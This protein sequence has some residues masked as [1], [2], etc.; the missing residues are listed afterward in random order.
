MNEETLAV[1][2]KQID[3]DIVEECAEF[4]TVETAAGASAASGHEAAPAGAAPGENVAASGREKATG[5]HRSGRKSE[6]P[7]KSVVSI[8]ATI[9]LFVAGAAAAIVLTVWN[10]NKK[11]PQETVVATGE[12]YASQYPQEDPTDDAAR[13]LPPTDAPDA[14]PDP[15][16]SPE[17]NLLYIVND[18]KE[19]YPHC[20]LSWSQV[21]VALAED[22]APSPM[23]A[24][25]VS[26][27]IQIMSLN[28]DDHTITYNGDFALGIEERQGLSELGIYRYIIYDA[29]LEEVFIQRH[30]VNA[31]VSAY[32]AKAELVR[33]LEEFFG[34]TEEPLEPY[35]VCV[36]VSYK[37]RSIFYTEDNESFDYYAYDYVF[38]VKKGSDV[39]PSPTICGTAT[40]GLTPTETPI[41][42]NAP[43]V[44][45][46]SSL[47]FAIVQDGKTISP[48]KAGMVQAVTYNGTEFVIGDL[49]ASLDYTKI[50]AAAPTVYYY[51]DFTEVWTKGEPGDY[52]V[53]SLAKVNKIDGTKAVSISGHC[54]RLSELKRFLPSD[55]T[56][57]QY[58]IDM[59]IAVVIT[60]RGD[61]VNEAGGYETRQVAYV[62]RI[63]SKDP[64]QATAR[65]DPTEEPSATIRI[66][67]VVIE[68][69]SKL[70]IGETVKLNCRVYPDNY[71]TGSISWKIVEGGEYAQL[72]RAA[73]TVKGVK[74]GTVRLRA[75]VEG[76]EIG[77]EQIISVE[78]KGLIYTPDTELDPKY[79]PEK[80]PQGI[81][82]DVYDQRR[83]Y[84]VYNMRTPEEVPLQRY[85][86][87][88]MDMTYYVNLD[89]A[90]GGLDKGG[91]KV[92]FYN[93]DFEYVGYSITN[94]S[95]LAMFTVK[96]S[97]NRRL[98]F[99]VYLRDREPEVSAFSKDLRQIMSGDYYSYGR[100]GETGLACYYKYVFVTDDR[101]GIYTVSFVNRQTG[102][103][104][105]VKANMLDWFFVL[106]DCT[107]YNINP[108]YKDPET[109]NLVDVPCLYS[110]PGL[111]G[112]IDAICY[113]E[114]GSVDNDAT[115][116]AD[117]PHLDY[118]VEGMHITIYLDGEPRDPWA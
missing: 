56:V 57:D 21:M 1:Y 110:W 29:N 84:L 22:E 46:D 82:G 47:P 10:R 101:D 48:Y 116:A 118:K 73:G 13:T 33:K 9:L 19:Y 52:Y 15:S 91:I 109:G 55:S 89:G 88:V 87:Y 53:G 65:P 69:A 18:G 67:T 60:E 113:V 93:D 96:N 35:Y 41:V 92:A 103:T 51:R 2:M 99:Y 20:E 97:E 37:T 104:A 71:N 108:G 78:E 38:A 79:M 106:A 50:S 75:Y 42:T 3:A 32:Y 6:K 107:R 58:G 61:Y 40:P 34:R 63:S 7:W 70:F 25:G 115:I 85:S 76:T 28:M 94:S 30:N 26:P 111:E 81:D 17:K 59:L 72:D 95:G 83:Y 114:G 68:M 66:Q 80:D 8:A 12:A 98:Y 43:E 4:A 64:A 102:E 90:Y 23:Y 54:S 24:D 31:P 39:R 62:F 105:E 74:K 77:Y 44:T 45:P 5:T 14:T 100:P 112:H 36:T 117:F 27:R 16:L 49:T 11:D 86:P